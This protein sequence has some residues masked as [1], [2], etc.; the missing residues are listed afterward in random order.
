MPLLSEC[1]QLKKRYSRSMNLERDLDDVDALT[2]YIV[3][4]RS[5]EALE[6][7]LSAVTSEGLSRCWTLT[8]AY[9]TGKSSFAHFLLS[10]CGPQE[11][12]KPAQKILKEQSFGGRDNLSKLAKKV[13]ERGFIRAVA[14]AQREPIAHTVVKALHRGVVEYYENRPGPKAA[15]LEELT[16]S[17]ARIKSGKSVDANQVLELARETSTKSVNGLIILLDEL[18]KGLEYA[19][20]SQSDGD[21]YLLQQIAELKSDA[22]IYVIGLLHQSFADYGLSLSTV[23]RTEWSK[24]QGRFED[25]AFTYSGPEALRLISHAIEHKP[26]SDLN[27]LSRRYANEWHRELSTVLPEA[28]YTSD[29]LSEI[30]PLHPIAAVVLPLLCNR[31]AQNDRSLFSFL[32]SEEPYSFTHFL[33]HTEIRKDSLPTLKLESLYDYFVDVVGASVHSRPHLSRWLEIQGRITESSGLHDEELKALKAIGILNLVATAG[34]LKA[35][36]NLVALSMCDSPNNEVEFKKWKKII[37]SLVKN[38]TVAYRKALDELRVWQGSDFNIDQSVQQLVQ[39]DS[40]SLDQILNLSAPMT[41]LIAQRHSY[42]FGTFRYFERR[43]IG[44]HSDLASLH[45]TTGSADGMV[46]YWVGDEPC[47][48]SPAN[49]TDGKPLIIMCASNVSVLHNAAYELCALQRIDAEAPELQTDGVARREVRQR[50]FQAKTRL[51][52]VLADSFAVNA[53]TD[54][55][56]LGQSKKYKGYREFMAG[57]SDVCDQVYSSTP[58]LLNELINRRDLTSQGAK[59]RR[60]L[61]EALLENFELPN[62]GLTGAGPEV[63]MYRSVLAKTGIHRKNEQTGLWEIGAPSDETLMPV[64]NAIESYCLDSIEHARPIKGL[65]QVLSEAPYGIKSGILPVLLAA[66]LLQHIDDICIYRDG[67][68]VPVLGPEHFE[69]LVKDAG[70]FSVKHFAS[71]GLRAQVFQEIEDLVVRNK[72]VRRHSRN[73]S[74]LSVVGPL[75][76]FVTGLPLYTKQTASISERAQAVRDAILAANEPDELL[77]TAIPKGL[78]QKA[79]VVGDKENQSKAHELKTGLLSVLKELQIAHDEMINECHQ[80]L[81]KAFKIEKESSRQALRSRGLAVSMSAHKSEFEAFIRHIIAEDQDDTA[82][83]K[84]VLAFIGDKG[85]ESWKD[86]DV[87]LFTDSVYQYANRFANFESLQADLKNSPGDG[88]EPKKITLTQPS[89]REEQKI[90]WINRSKEKTVAELVEQIISEKLSEVPELHDAI[91]SKLTER[92]LSNTADSNRGVKQ[93]A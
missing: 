7:I 20:L 85:T 31:F 33:S 89:G 16:T 72:K 91:L 11:L 82:W 61:I 41:P 67:T 63:S 43:Y 5:S 62:L 92:L 58:V 86:Y 38:S 49:T 60:E 88:F 37:D 42:R 25:I 23:Q 65:F 80:Q 29:M 51:D 27:K 6:R 81:C 74:L 78:G 52:A 40:R 83:L 28:S 19:S 18:G 36:H 56:V 8:G 17:I 73:S 46:V 10:L 21:L 3:T 66:M 44:S 15:V 32:T 84:K 4:P 12:R 54:C 24:I 69:L 90:L 48:K 53:K 34:S 57:L 75:I 76:S 70:R 59:A 50:A 71:S 13:A 55:K 47:K 14:T 77:F 22:G 68:F 30:L 9:G 1:I 39:S 64:W 93:E 26:Q 45:C 79:I 87:E 35:S 2:G